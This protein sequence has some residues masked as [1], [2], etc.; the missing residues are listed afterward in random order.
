M[1]V[2]FDQEKGAGRAVWRSEDGAEEITLCSVDLAA[3]GSEPSVREHF[4]ALT[5]AV[6]D[7]HRRRHVA[8][9]IAS[10]ASRLEG[11]LCATCTAPEADDVRHRAGQISDVT[12]LQLSPAGYPAGCCR[13]RIV[14]AFSSQPNWPQPTARR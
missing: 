4:D 9:P 5:Q 7:H 13:R 14:G 12:E 1:P 6:A 10:A 8:A 2:Y 11:I 3:Y